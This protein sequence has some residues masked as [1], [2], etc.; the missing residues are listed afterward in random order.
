MPGSNE[1]V[2]HTGNLLKATLVNKY[3][4]RCPT[5]YSK[6]EKD[7]NC[8]HDDIYIE[9]TDHLTTVSPGISFGSALLLTKQHDATDREDTIFRLTFHVLNPFPTKDTY[10]AVQGVGLILDNI[11][12]IKIRCVS[13]EVCQDAWYDAAAVAGTPRIDTVTTYKNK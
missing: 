10:L 11:A 6:A 9:S 4:Q 2:L 5:D 13:T 3:T 1:P 7:A 8:I 12:D